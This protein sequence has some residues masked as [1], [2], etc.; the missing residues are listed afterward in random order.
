MNEDNIQGTARMIG[1]KLEDTVGGLTGDTKTQAQGKVDQLAGKAQQ[2]MGDAKEAVASAADEAG[3]RIGGLAD[4]VATTASDLGQ[5]AYEKTADAAHE[6]GE[7]LR[8]NPL[9]IMV[10]AGLIG[11]AVGYFL[12]RPPYERAIRAGRAR[13]SYRD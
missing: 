12:G 11:V 7:K 8:E 3:S 5:N 4:R 1:G 2:V 9:A 10:A 6:V 13:L